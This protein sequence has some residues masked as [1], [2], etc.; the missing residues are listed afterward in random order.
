MKI[1][2]STLQ[3]RLTIFEEKYIQDFSKVESFASKS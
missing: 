2:L 1:R 3:F